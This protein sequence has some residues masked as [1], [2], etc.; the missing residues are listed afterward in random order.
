VFKGLKAFE[1]P[2]TRHSRHII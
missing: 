1:L 2:L